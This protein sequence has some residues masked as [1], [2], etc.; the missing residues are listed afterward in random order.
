ELFGEI[1]EDRA[2]FEDADWGRAAAV[3]HRRDFRIRVDLDE[4]AAE[5]VAL[6]DADQ[7]GVVLGTLVPF[8][9]QLLEH[10]GDLDA[11]RRALR[12]ELQRV[13]ADRQFLFVL[14]AGGRAVDV[15]EAAHRAVRLVP[16]PDLRR[17]VYGGIGHS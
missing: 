6:A 17:R 14:C 3:D 8:R 10:D 9:Q 16:G 11:V 15:G 5:L 1:D 13:L 4:A 2:G 12:I 7:P